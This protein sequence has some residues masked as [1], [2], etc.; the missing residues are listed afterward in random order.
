MSGFSEPELKTKASV[1]MPQQIDEIHEQLIKQY[2]FSKKIAQ[3][4]TD[5]DVMLKHK[6]GTISPVIV[7]MHSNINYS[8]ELI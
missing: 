8:K 2:I 6:N 7:K 1:F 5:K 4:E 3:E